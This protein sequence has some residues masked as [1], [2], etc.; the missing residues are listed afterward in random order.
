MK[1]KYMTTTL[2]APDIS[3]GGCAYSIKKALGKVPGISTVDVD[4][5]SKAVTVTHDEATAGRAT[6]T[7]ALG[8][9]GFPVSESA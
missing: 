8:R 4:I 5:D 3:C 9:A 1:G 6:I 7:E 2:T